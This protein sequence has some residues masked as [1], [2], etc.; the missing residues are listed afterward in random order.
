MRQVAKLDILDVRL[1]LASGV[2]LPSTLNSF[3]R[4]FGIQWTIKRLWRFLPSFIGVCTN[5]RFIIFPMF[6]AFAVGGV[7]GL[8]SAQLT[9][10][11][12]GDVTQDRNLTAADALQVFKQSLGLS[13]PP[14]NTCQLSI[15][16]VYPRPS[17]PDG[18]ITAAGA[19]R[20]FQRLPVCRP[21]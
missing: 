19:S 16:D 1:S 21:A 11:P 18:I 6:L 4:E 10:Q 15:A 3:L 2:G 14:L 9:C 17:A 5:C 20:I 12:N 7:P 8:S 13:D